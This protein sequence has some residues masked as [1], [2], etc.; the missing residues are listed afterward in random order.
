MG[1]MQHF[2]LCRQA[3]LKRTISISIT[4]SFSLQTSSTVCCKKLLLDSTG[5]DWL[6]A[7]IHMGVE[8]RGD[9]RPSVTHT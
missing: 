1:Q 5:G 6:T 2:T 8:S 9:G 7:E 3:R 4:A